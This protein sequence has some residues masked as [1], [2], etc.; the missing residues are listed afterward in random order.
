MSESGF[1]FLHAHE[2]ASMYECVCMSVYMWPTHMGKNSPCGHC[3]WSRNIPLWHYRTLTLLQPVCSHSTQM[4]K[5]KRRYLWSLTRTF[6]INYATQLVCCVCV[7]N[8]CLF[9]ANRNTP[10][11]KNRV[12]LIQT[13]VWAPKASQE[14]VEF[15]FANNLFIRVDFFVFCFVLPSRCFRFPSRCCCCC[16]WYCFYSVVTRT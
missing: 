16:C 12:F 10:K 2:H 11:Y 5:W 6:R 14:F 3:F 4:S 1:P 9:A 15:A 8:L 13:I 7:H